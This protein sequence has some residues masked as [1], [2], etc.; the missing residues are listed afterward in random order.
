MTKFA[1]TRSDV[2]LPFPPALRWIESPGCQGQLNN[3]I[4][5][6]DKTHGLSLMSCKLSAQLIE[7]DAGL[8]RNGFK[9]KSFIDSE[10]HA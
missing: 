10:R 4:E 6:V 1:S 9:A 8:R 5:L 3:Y 7:I 2:G